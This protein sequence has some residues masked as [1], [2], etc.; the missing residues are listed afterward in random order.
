MDK[1]LIDTT[2]ILPLFGIKI[3][4]EGIEVRLPEIFKKYKVIYSSLSIVE[5]KWIILKLIKKYPSKKDI[6]LKSFRNGLKVLLTEENIYKTR[7]TTPEVEDIADLLLLK[8]GIKDYFDRMIYATAVN[9]ESILMT[10]DMELKSLENSE[11]PK[12]KKI[13]SWEEIIR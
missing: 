12:P 4:L 9:Q 10:E 11:L 2:Y 3:K 1:I 6:F 13:I 5:A 8:A 7:L